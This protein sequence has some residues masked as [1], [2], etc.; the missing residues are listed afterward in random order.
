MREPKLEPWYSRQIWALWAAV[1]TEL[2]TVALCACKSTPTILNSCF[3]FFS[4][5]SFCFQSA[6]HDS[7]N[8]LH[9]LLRVLV[10]DLF[11][12]NSDDRIVDTPPWP[13][14]EQEGTLSHSSGETPPFEGFHLYATFPRWEEDYLVFLDQKS[15]NTHEGSHKS[16][17]YFQTMFQTHFLHEFFLTLSVLTNISVIHSDTNSKPHPYPLPFRKIEKKKF[18][19]VTRGPS[20]CLIRGGWRLP[21]M[22]DG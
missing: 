9:N 10:S 1:K 15:L 12:M 18:P 17:R 11:V 16:V 3:L 21:C 4:I 13:R 20:P 14:T 19:L 7:L 6:G 5:W 8:W 22:D 2:Y